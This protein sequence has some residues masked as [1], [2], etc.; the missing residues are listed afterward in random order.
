VG[1][2]LL[3]EPARLPDLVVAQPKTVRMCFLPQTVL[4]LLLL[5]LSWLIA[6][7]QC[8]ALLAYRALHALRCLRSV[9]RC[10]HWTG[11]RAV[12]LRNLHHNMAGPPLVTKTPGRP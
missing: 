7:F 1:I 6:L 4:P 2:I 8:L 12:M 10:C 11:H 3:R 9:C 5:F